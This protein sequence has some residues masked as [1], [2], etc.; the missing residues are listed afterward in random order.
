MGFTS[1]AARDAGFGLDESSFFGPLKVFEGLNLA[2]SSSRCVGQG[3]RDAKGA[4]VTR[5]GTGVDGGPD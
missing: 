5:D 3:L 2:S 1:D 4:S